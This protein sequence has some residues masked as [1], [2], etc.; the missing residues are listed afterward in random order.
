MARTLHRSL[1]A[2]CAL[3]ALVATAGAQEAVRRVPESH[4]QVTLSFAP[5]VKQAAPAVVNVFTTKTVREQRPV[6]PLLDDPFFRHFFGDQFGRERRRKENSLGSGVI[7]RPDGLVVTNHH[8]IEGA[9]RIKVVLTDRREFE[10][11]IVKDDERTDLAVLKIEPPAGEELPFLELGDSDQL[12]VGDLVLAIGNPFGVGQTVT[13]GI[14]SALA[15]T[16]VGITDYN[17]FVQTDAAINPGNSGGALLQMDGRL[18]GVNTAIFSRSGGSQGIGFAVPANMVRTVVDSVARDGRIRRPWLGARGQTVTAEIAD[19]LGLSRPAGV[20]IST[21]YP[22]GPAD[23]AGLRSGD[24]VVALDDRPVFD[25][26]ALRFRHATGLLGR[27]ATVTVLRNGEEITLTITREVAPEVPPRD[28]TRLTGRHPLAGAT[29]VNL[30]PAVSDE[31]GLELSLSGVLVTEVN[32]RSV[33]SR[34]G[35]RPMDIVLSVNGERVDAV[36]GLR[37]LLAARA[38]QWRISIRR[39]DRVLSVSVSG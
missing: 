7:V 32:R 1:A 39:G 10:A 31:L 36:A 23:R 28:E 6:S 2:L 24:V 33:A 4:E 8:V 21:I 25:E 30:S 37:E 18:A 20:L 3:C 29:V 34:I 17:F 27:D 11:T 12:E 5:L 9:D 14:V 15:R 13:S 16:S 35:L 26:G 22:D 19:A 38:S